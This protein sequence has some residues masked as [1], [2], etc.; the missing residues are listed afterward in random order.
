LHFADKPLEATI[1]DGVLE[2]AHACD[3]CDRHSRAGW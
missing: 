1:F 2:A 3:W